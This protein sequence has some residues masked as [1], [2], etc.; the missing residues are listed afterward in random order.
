MLAGRA[1]HRVVTH[2]DLDRRGVPAD[3]AAESLEQM[4]TRLRLNR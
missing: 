4:L 1:C 3:E 2:A